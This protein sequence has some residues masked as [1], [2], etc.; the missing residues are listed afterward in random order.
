MRLKHVYIQ[1]LI[2][3]ILANKSR[4]DHTQKVSR[5]TELVFTFYNT[6]PPQKCHVN[7]YVIQSCYMSTEGLNFVS[8]CHEVL[9]QREICDWVNKI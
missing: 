9:Q 6:H 2:N 3:K 8:F 7:S 5:R 1:I 4:D